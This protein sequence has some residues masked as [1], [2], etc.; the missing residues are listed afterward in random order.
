MLGSNY[1]AWFIEPR[2]GFETDGYGAVFTGVNK[3]NGIEFYPQSGMNEFGLAFT[4]LAMATPENG[5]VKLGKKRID[6]RA[7]YLK[8]ILHS[9]KTVEEA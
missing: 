7:N 1:D 5:Q 6:S 8:N 3:F 4:V 9:C 2:I